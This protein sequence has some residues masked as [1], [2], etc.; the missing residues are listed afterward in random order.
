MHNLRKYIDIIN[1]NE[2]LKNTLSLFLK[3]ECGP[4]FLKTNL[5]AYR[6]IRHGQPDFHKPVHQI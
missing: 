2:I 6:G 3:D 1:E 4:W 5:P